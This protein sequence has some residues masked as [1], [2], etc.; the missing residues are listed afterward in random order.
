MS[1]SLGYAIAPTTLLQL[2][3][4]CQQ[5]KQQKWTPIFL[6]QSEAFVVEHLAAL[7]L[8]T[9]KTP[10][11][12]DVDVPQFIDLIL[13]KV[14]PPEL[15]SDFKKGMSLFIKKFQTIFKK[16]ISEGDANNFDIVLSSYFKISKKDQKSIFEL[17]AQKG[18]VNTPDVYYIYKFLLFVREHTLFGY[19]TSKKVGTEILDYN[20]IPGYYEACIPLGDNDNASAI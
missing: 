8:P 5:E 14:V 6:K 10:G 19:Y 16:E 7:I 11:A 20:P 1:L 4:S 2:L 3:S 9:T 13:H 12:L 17:L 18:T 15:K